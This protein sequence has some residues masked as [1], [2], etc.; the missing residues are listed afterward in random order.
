MKELTLYEAFI[1]FLNQQ[2]K[3]IIDRYEA[4]ITYDP[5][6]EEFALREEP[7]G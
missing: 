3:I 4:T 7:D 6:N 5:Y 2:P 1:K